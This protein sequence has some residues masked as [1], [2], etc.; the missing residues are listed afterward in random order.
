MKIWTK[1][2]QHRDEL[3][4]ACCACKTILKRHVIVIK[5]IFFFSRDHIHYNTHNCPESYKK[6]S[7][8]C[9]VSK[10]VNYA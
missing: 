2:S 8:L 10:N 1:F 9:I 5:A 6:V 7:D 3:C 4:C